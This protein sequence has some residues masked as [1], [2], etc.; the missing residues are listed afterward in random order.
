MDG[1]GRAAVAL[2]MLVVNVRNGER[3]VARLIAQ[4]TLGSK[5]AAHEW[6][7]ARFG[8]LFVIPATMILTDQ[9]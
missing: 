7:R 2:G 4:L 1:T 3:N 6:G 8:T 9:P 5:V